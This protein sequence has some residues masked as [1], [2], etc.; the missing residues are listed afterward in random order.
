MLTVRK[1]ACVAAYA[2][3]LVGMFGQVVTE[4]FRTSTADGW[5]FAGTGYTPTLT[6][7]GA[8]PAGDGW[9]RLT[10]LGTYQATSAYYNTAF[11]A[12]NATIYASFNYQ[13]WGGTGADGITFFLFDGSKTFSIGADGGS[14]GYAQKTG[15]DGLNGGYLGIALDEWGNFSAGTEGRSGGIGQT[16][17]SFSVRGPGSGTTGYD[18]LGGTGT[19][20]TSI[21][22]PS[23][24]SRP[25][26]VNTVQVLLSATNQLTV[27]LQQGSLAAQTVLSMDL[28][29][30]ARPETLMF[31]FSSGT[32]AST[33]YHEIRNLNVTTLVANL[34]DGGAGD[35][36]WGSF[37]NWN[38]DIVPAAGADILFDN[39]FVSSAQS[40]TLGSQR[41]LRSLAIDAPFSYSLSGG[42]IHF[43]A[44][45]VPGFT[46]IQVSQTRGSAAHTISAPITMANDIIVRNNSAGTLSL[47][48]SLATGGNR[49]TFDGVGTTTVSGVISGTGSIL[50][51]DG[52]VTNL[53]AANTYS[54]GTTVSGGTLSTNSNTGFGTGGIVL[55]GGTL[56][57]SA[58]N[59]IANNIALTGDAALSGITVSGTL[60]HSSA[61]RV[62]NLSNSTLAGNVSLSEGNTARTMTVNVD[63]GTSAITGI[64]SNG[65]T[66]AGG[67]TKTGLGTLTL[68]GSNTYT[69]TTTI[70]QGTLQLGASN[71]LADASGVSIG[72]SGTLNLAGH[73]ERIGNL[74]A[75]G[76]ATLDFGSTSGANTFVFANYSAPASGVMVVNNWE[77]GIDTLATTVGAQNV[78]SIYFSGY[79]VAQLAGSA[80]STIYGNAFRLTPTTPTGV[81]WSGN[82][83]G[84]YSTNQNWVGNTRPSNSQ[85]AIFSDVGSARNTVTV[86]ANRQVAGLRFASSATSSYTLQGTSTLT[87]TGAVPFIQQ[88]SDLNHA[89]N[90]PLS[91]ASTTVVDITS[92]GN[93]TI[94][95]NISGNS[96]NLIRDGSGSGK[97]ILSGTNTYAGLF[98]NTGVVQAAS[99]GSLGSGAATVS[100]G[101]G[102]ELSGGIS[103][104]NAITLSGSGV[105]GTGALRSVSGNNTAS[106]AITLGSD[107]TLGAD[108]GAS[109]TLTGAITGATRTVTATGAGN[110]TISGAIGTTS[111]GFVSNSLGTVTLSGTSANTFTG[112]A[113][114]NSGTLVLSKTAGVNALAGNLVIGDGSGTDTVR[115]G[116]SNQIADA[117]VVTIQ[118]GGVFHLNGF[119]ETIRGLD[120]A[121][122][123]SV[124]LGSGNLTISGAGESV[125]SG[126]ISG[127]GALNKQGTGKISFSNS[128]GSFS[129]PVNISAGI[130]NVSGGHSDTLGTGTVTVTGTGNLELQGGSAIANAVTIN[131]RGTGALDGAIQ[132]IAGNNT[133]SGAVTVTGLSRVQSDNGTLTFTNSINLGSNT[134]NFGGTGDTIVSGVIG[135]AGSITKDGSGT[136]HLGGANSFTGSTTISAGKV[137]LL[138]SGVLHDSMAVTIGGAGTLALNGHSEAI[139]RISGSGSVDF[140]TAGTS[141]LSLTAGVSNF[142]G[143]LLGDGTLFLGAGA[144]LT[145]GADISNTSLSIIL[146]GGTLNLNGY[147]GTFG[148]LSVTGNSTIDFGASADSTISIGSLSFGSPLVTLAITGWS[149][150]QDYFYSRSDPGIQGAPP[151]SQVVFSGFTGDDSRWV[152]FDSQITPVPEPSTYGAMLLG[153]LVAIF[154]WRRNRQRAIAKADRP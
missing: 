108:G 50:K 93:L 77:Q 134:L 27:T 104:S 132:N 66:G 128:N 1:I 48:G 76:G 112:N 74:T 125:Y 24:G 58:S 2:A 100:S 31:G 131:S 137:S 62:L 110:I 26:T 133:V 113:V 122:G 121:A 57:S 146:A 82:N 75:A 118:S 10:S 79:G 59:T 151:L 147:T 153:S 20:G 150:A 83:S 86:D 44:G 116:A 68:S 6:S 136:L 154:A 49:V 117:S 54:G 78:S 40:I 91:L 28:S 123:A 145:M 23:V 52:G 89:I 63:A 7:G 11:A 97:L 73:S 14:L 13:S 109:L 35:G 46:G 139:G 17:D 144:T 138:S 4:T 152:G 81:V 34:W 87:L 70:S 42:S 107:A 19:L 120:G 124:V 129:G 126:T 53:L 5:V 84:V 43:D 96:S 30:Y 25:A 47:D 60:T 143:Q 12:T 106:G 38:P 99:S 101:A 85:I 61:N 94:G 103:P 148:S 56:A 98:V 102:L 21:D 140:G 9:L 115:L 64:I 37:N 80:T 18:Y 71:V 114:V 36:Q 3:C 105:S 33:N 67:I 72:A 51:A 111:G 149:D 16:P 45:G 141:M 90:A 39:T 119:N 135:G 88:Q 22:T 32:G 29:G 95:G 130:V 41:T 69:G 15:V 92:S 8:D 55:S 127:T 142:S 65:G